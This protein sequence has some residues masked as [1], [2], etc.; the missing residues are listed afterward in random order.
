MKTL[1]KILLVDDDQNILTTLRIR[2]ESLGYQVVVAQDGEQGLALCESEMPDLVLLDLKLPGINGLEV[3]KQIKSISPSVEVIMLTAEGTIETSVRAI[4]LG[5]YDYLPKP[6][7]PKQLKS[8][9][10]KAL[11][12][13]EVNREIRRFRKQY[14]SLGAFGSIIG[15]APCMLETYRLIEQVSQTDATVLITGE[16]GTGKELVARTIHELSPRR[17]SPFIPVNCAAITPTLWESEIFGHEKGAF[18]GAAARKMGCFE[19]ANQGTLFLDE[20]SEMP[21]DN[22]A[23]FLRVLED[24]RFRRLGGSEEI[25][26]NVRVIA[27]TNRELLKAIELNSFRHDVYYRLNHC[28]IDL[29]PLHKRKEDIPHLIQAFLTDAAARNNKPFHTLS[30]ETMELLMDY[31]WPG[32]IRELKN[33]LERAVVFC[34]E[35]E[36]GPK[37]F[38]ESLMDTGTDPGIVTVPVG[39][40][41]EEAEQVLLRKTLRSTGGNKAK[42]ARL[43]GISLKTFYNKLHKY[44]LLKKTSS[45]S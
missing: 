41:L 15:I 24:H 30:Q 29:P 40:P 28:N 26:V 6:I 21:F 23:K 12:K 44:Q 4:K 13:G 36:I 10:E 43:L 20:I 3:L 22:Q 35:K 32:N 14:K 7:N 31:P 1:S 16:S 5:A 19:L 38:K 8:L 45:P 18:T 9:V 27:S 2:L 11:K 17:E 33:V 37:Y 34:E 25:E 39:T 42:A